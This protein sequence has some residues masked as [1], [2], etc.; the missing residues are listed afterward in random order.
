MHAHRLMMVTATASIEKPRMIP[1]TIPIPTTSSSPRQT[2]HRV[3]VTMY[4]VESPYRK[5]N[6]NRMSLFQLIDTAVCINE[7]K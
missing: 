5:K 1:S 4:A 2:Q 6:R 7:K 3:S